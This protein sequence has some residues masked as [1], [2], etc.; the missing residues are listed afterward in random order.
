MVPIVHKQYLTTLMKQ[1]P[2]N[3]FSA[4]AARVNNLKLD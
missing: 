2:V 3:I 4:I 1:T